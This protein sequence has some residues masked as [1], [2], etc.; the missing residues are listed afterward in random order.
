MFTE[1]DIETMSEAAHNAWLAEKQRR[2][3][4]TWPNERGFEQ[5]VPYAQCPD[6]VKEFDRVVVRAIAEAMTA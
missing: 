5:M 6:D 3:V 1:D 2:G 4:V